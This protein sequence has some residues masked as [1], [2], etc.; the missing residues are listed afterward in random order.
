[1]EKEQNGMTDRQ[2]L[3]HLKEILEVALGCRTLRQ[4]IK[5]LRRLI[6]QYEQ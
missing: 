5:K 6:E 1:M 3:H 2:F 4:F